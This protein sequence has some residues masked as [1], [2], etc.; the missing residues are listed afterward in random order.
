MADSCSRRTPPVGSVP[1]D[2]KAENCVV[3][4]SRDQTAEGI[5]ETLF[6]GLAQHKRNVDAHVAGDARY[7]A[8]MVDL[9]RRRARH[10]Q[11]VE[12]GRRLR[13]HPLDVEMGA[14]D[15]TV[16]LNRQHPPEQLAI[17]GVHFV[18]ILELD[19]VGKHGF[20]P[21]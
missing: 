11:L 17:L 8:E 12:P 15:L 10:D 13:Q 6:V 14:A 18:Q 4:P 5:D 20:P 2:Q 7:F 9:F 16:G 1:P 19:F 21:L 3:F